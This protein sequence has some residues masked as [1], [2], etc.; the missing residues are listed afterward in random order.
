MNEKNPPVKIVRS[1]TRN[2]LRTEA[3]MLRKK[4]GLETQEKFPIMEFLELIMPQIDS[5]FQVLPVEDSEL[6]GRAAETFPD[7]HLMRVKQSVYDAACNGGYWARLVMAHELGHYIC[8]G[9][10]S[11]SYAYPMSGEKIP[12]AVDPE[13]QADIFAAELLAPVNLIQDLSD[14][15]VSKRFGVPRSI[16]RI[17]MNQAKKIQRRHHRK[18]QQAHAKRNG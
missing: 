3:Y 12:S 15:L 9:D 10:E 1:R 18:R 14:Y 7:L 2:Q 17:Q 16:A 4:F 6:P 13:R 8:H 5:E 11:P